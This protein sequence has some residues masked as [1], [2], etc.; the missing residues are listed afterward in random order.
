V[1]DVHMRKLMEEVSPSLSAQI[2][3][4]AEQVAREQLEEF[5]AQIEPVRRSSEDSTQRNLE[6]MRQETQAEI[7][8]AGIQAR[9]IYKEES[10][11]A[12]KV[13]SVCVDSA[14]DSLNRAG[15]EA[16]SKL[17][18]AYQTLEL[19]LKKAAEECLPRLADE[20]ASVLEKF[21]AET[22]ALAAQ[23]Q[24]EVESTAREFSEKASGDISE[25]LEGAVEGALE[26]VARDF[27]KQ[28]EDAL[29]L[30]KEGLRSAQQQC[31]DETQRQL[32]AA[33]ESTLTS[34]ESEAG[35][36]L[37]SFRERLH[38]TLLE[39]QAEQTKEMEKELQ[40]SLQGLLESLRTQ[41]HLTADESA[42]RVTAEVRSRAEQALQ[43]LP[44][45]LYKGVGMAAL[46]A[47]EWEE[48]AK[49][50]LEAHLSHVLEVFQKQLEGLTMAAQERQRSDAEAL[51]GLLQSRLHQAAR[52]FEG[53]QADASQS[54][55]VAR[56]ESRKSPFQSL[57]ASRDPLRPALD[58]LVEKQQKIIEEALSTFRSRL[59]R[60]LA[61]HAPKEQQG[62]PGTP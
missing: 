28:A 48:Q 11:T 61:D 51:K 58:P 47:K 12:A 57:R 53:V 50:H 38:T 2:E 30:L 16:V 46:V 5:K 14:V 35:V 55:G 44:D 54:K 1:V 37:A 21:R 33:R 23:L 19:S 13:I 36:N 49:T 20:S 59:G 42:A 34:L 9:K 40:T 17:Q 39:M 31:V 56:E 25:K 60:I 62:P 6:R 52:L 26:L 3:R 24:S 29:E 15:D 32:A 4:S 18:A 7:L 43:E 41:V 45:R 22:Q 10:G 27:G 8:N